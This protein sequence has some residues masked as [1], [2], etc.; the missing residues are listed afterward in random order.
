MI[1]N[2]IWHETFHC[3]LGQYFL[4]DKILYQKKNQYHDIKIFHNSIMGNIMTI[5]DVVQTTEKDEFIYHEML[6]HV[7]IFSHGLV[8]DVLIIG[9]GDGGTLREVCKHKN[10]SNITMVEIDINIINLCKKYFPNHSDN[11]YND[12][13]L[14]LIIDDG[15][16][17]IKNTHQKFDLIISDSTDP[18]GCGKNLFLSE[19]YL[20]CKKNLKKNGIFVAQNGTSFLQI[21]E[22]FLT[23][24]NLKKY[25]H[26]CTFYQAIVPTYYGGAIMFAWG[27]DN[28]KLR[29]IDQ[30]ILKS[31]I[32]EKKIIFKYYNPKIHISS[33]SLPQYIINKLDT[34]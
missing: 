15:L 17:F 32:K 19:F 28:Q 18:I 12:S 27:S 6:S 26:D 14:K 13:R 1:K 31:R 21:D 29:Y 8:K 33:F 16:N 30:K 11:A 23:Y 20:N 7:P 5:D 3:H 2:K 24:K 34:S 4:I 25:F 9:G 22:I 10:I